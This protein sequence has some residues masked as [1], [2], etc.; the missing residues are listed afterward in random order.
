MTEFVILIDGADGGKFTV[1]AVAADL[2]GLW[3]SEQRCAIR[4]CSVDI[5]QLIPYRYRRAFKRTTGRFWY[6]DAARFDGGK[7]VGGSVPY[8]T[9]ENSR[10]KYMATLYAL[11]VTGESVA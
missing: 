6:D 5:E 2:V 3:D 8:L 7:V 11:P 9:L 1:R 10:G 4:P